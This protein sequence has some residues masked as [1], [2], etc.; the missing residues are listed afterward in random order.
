MVNKANWDSDERNKQNNLGRYLDSLTRHQQQMIKGISSKHLGKYLSLEEHDFL[1]HLKDCLTIV[2]LSKLSKEEK[3]FR[4]RVI[5]ET[6]AVWRRHKA[7][8]EQDTK[9]HKKETEYHEER[10]A[11][12]WTPKHHESATVR[13]R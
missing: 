7:E 9:D 2:E 3:Q 6:M 1:G 11:K 4:N 8:L 12:G 10:V 13:T 5:R